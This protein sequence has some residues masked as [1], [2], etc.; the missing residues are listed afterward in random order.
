MRP[1]LCRSALKNSTILDGNCAAGDLIY[2][3]G[4][5]PP[6]TPFSPDLNGTALEFV[7]AAVGAGEYVNTFSKNFTAVTLEDF[8]KNWQYTFGDPKLKALLEAQPILATWD[9]HVRCCAAQL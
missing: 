7:T 8:R 6:V 1:T 3:D 4:P 9:D 2:A 5:I